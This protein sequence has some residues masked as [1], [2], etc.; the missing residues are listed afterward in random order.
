MSF[1][2]LRK[3]LPKP[4]II[5]DLLGGEMAEYGME[6]NEDEEDGFP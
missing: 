2:E 6:V 3:W 4:E 5:A 1:S